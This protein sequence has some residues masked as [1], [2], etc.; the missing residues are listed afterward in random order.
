[1]GLTLFTATGN[2]NAWERG[3]GGSLTDAAD[4]FDPVDP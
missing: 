2:A 3:Q 4:L 1:M